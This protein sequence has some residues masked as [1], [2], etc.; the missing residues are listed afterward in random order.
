M[1]STASNY[2]IPRM[3]TGQAFASMAVLLGLVAAGPTLTRS[4]KTSSPFACIILLYGVMMFASSY[5]EEEQHFWYWATSAWLVLLLIK[6]Y[7]SFFAQKLGAH[8][9]L[10]LASGYTQLSQL[11]PSLL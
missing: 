5:V 4:V 9:D 8:K 6:R 11:F 1:S 10:A 7:V 3:F 2:D